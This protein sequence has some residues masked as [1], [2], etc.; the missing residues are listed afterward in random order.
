M[1]QLG[2]E[3]FFQATSLYSADLGQ[4]LT[5]VPTKT[6]YQATGLTEATLGDKV[7]SIEIPFFRVAR[8]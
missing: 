8:P 7:A 2:T 4:G 1:T 6:F 3:A 5:A